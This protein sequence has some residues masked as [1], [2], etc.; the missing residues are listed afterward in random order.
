M[1][2]VGP[3]EEEIVLLKKTCE[4][5]FYEYSNLSESFRACTT[6]HFRRVEQQ[7]K[8]GVYVVRQRDAQEVLYIGKSGT[9]DSQGQFKAQDIPGRLKNVKGGDVSADEWFRDLFQEKGVLVIE[10]IFLSTSKSPAFVEAAL[11]QAYLNE[12]HCLPYK[13]KSL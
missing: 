10:Y 11:L 7:E 8:Y 5:G 2:T 3:F 1:I 13:N 6:R 12:Y 4:H 9:I